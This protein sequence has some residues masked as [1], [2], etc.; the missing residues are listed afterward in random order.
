MMAKTSKFSTAC[1]MLILA[2]VVDFRNNIVGAID[3]WDNARATFYG[4]ISGRGTEGKYG[5]ISK[6]SK[7][8]LAS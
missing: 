6:F 2:L 5:C 8:L 7:F 1:T 3:G 4:D